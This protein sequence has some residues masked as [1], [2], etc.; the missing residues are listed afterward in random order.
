MKIACIRQYDS[1]GD[2]I[3]INGF[4][5]YIIKTS[6]YD[7]VILVL[8]VEEVRRKHCEMLY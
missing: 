2:W 7:K 1:H 3:N 8:E 6:G 5:R 4:I